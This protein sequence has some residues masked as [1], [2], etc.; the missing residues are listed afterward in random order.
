MCLLL[1]TAQGRPEDA[2]LSKRGVKIDLGKI[3]K[4]CFPLLPCS[5][6]SLQT[7]EPMLKLKLT[8]PDAT[9][10][11]QTRPFNL[12]GATRVSTIHRHTHANTTGKPFCD[13]QD[14]YGDSQ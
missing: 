14:E 13:P 4:G 9:V 8:T 2:G 6:R 3:Y 1:V 12:T 11:K 7:A 5:S 10:N